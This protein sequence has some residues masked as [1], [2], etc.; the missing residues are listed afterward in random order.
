MMYSRL[1]LARNL[2]KDDGVVFIS[3][4]D[5][6]RANVKKLCNEIFGEDNFQAN[7]SWQKRYTRSNNT[8]DFTTVVEH[9]LVYSKSSE[10]I[11]NLL[12]RSEEADSRYTNPDNDQRG[13]WKGASFLNPATPSQRPNLCYPIVNPKTKQETNPTTNAWRRSKEEFN[14]L[15]EKIV[16]TGERIAPSQFRQSKCF[17]QKLED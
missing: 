6:E 17:Y 16:C 4:D 5:G 9:I 11:V 13:V 3:I 14:K 1:K 8:V 2:L 12:P 7:V 15:L 10:F